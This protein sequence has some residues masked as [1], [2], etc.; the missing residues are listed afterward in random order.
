[1]RAGAGQHHGPLVANRS[2]VVSRVKR[3]I[4][5]YQVKLRLGPGLGLQVCAQLLWAKHMEARQ[6][7]GTTYAN[8]GLACPC[9]VIAV[10]TTGH[11]KYVIYRVTG[12]LQHHDGV[13]GQ[14]RIA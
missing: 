14:G 12:D 1:M 13:T 11:L 5:S 9:D 10:D 7:V 3:A 4:V 2:V 8:R 6:H